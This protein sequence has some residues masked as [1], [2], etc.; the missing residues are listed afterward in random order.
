MLV[1]TFTTLGENP[2]CLINFRVYIMQTTKYLDLDCVSLEKSAVSLLVAQ[3][4]GP[5]IISLCFN[6]GDNL[7]AE[8]PDF[9]TERS[10]GKIFHFYGGHRLWHAPEVMPRTY[11]PDDGLV[12]VIP[13][14]NG[15]SVTQPVE[16]ETGIEKNLQISLVEDKPQVLVRHRLTNRNL[17]SVECAPWAITQF[18]T[19]GVV[20]LPQSRRQTEVLLNRSLTFWPYTDLTSPQVSRGNSGLSHGWGTLGDR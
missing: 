12:E 20:I 2:F 6:G 3:S 17:W 1:Y 13:I 10:D 8:L 4:V 18:R 11:V 16:V 14:Q 19:G 7:F 15:L 5:R 9:V